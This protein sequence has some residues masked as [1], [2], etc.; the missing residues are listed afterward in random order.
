MVQVRFFESFDKGRASSVSPDAANLYN[1][2]EDTMTILSISDTDVNR[3]YQ[4]RF[5]VLNRAASSQWIQ[6]GVIARSALTVGETVRDVPVGISTL[7]VSFLP[8]EA[9][10][11]IYLHNLEHR[12]LVRALAIELS[13]I[14]A[15]DQRRAQKVN[16]RAGEREKT[17]VNH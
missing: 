11:Q 15:L 6:I 12:G 10:A 1:D 13:E 5:R 7:E 14:S 3:H 9:H 16:G 4:M 17:Q 8:H 2:R